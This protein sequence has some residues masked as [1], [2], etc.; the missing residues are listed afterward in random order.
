MRKR[1]GERDLC[2]YEEHYIDIFYSLPAD[3]LLQRTRKTTVNTNHIITILF[4]YY[5]CDVVIDDK[6][7]R[8]MSTSPKEFITKFTTNPHRKN[9]PC[10]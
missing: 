9:Y 5:S 1:E 7:F 4:R 3:D 8:F 6:P 2:V 10:I